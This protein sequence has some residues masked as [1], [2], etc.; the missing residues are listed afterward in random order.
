MVMVMKDVEMCVVYTSRIAYRG[1]DRLD[2][3]VKSGRGLGTLLAPTWELVGGIK[4]HETQGIDPRWVK[5]SP[6]T[7]EQY[8]QGYYELLRARYQPN[9]EGFLAILRLDRVVCCYC[10]AG[11]FC[12][13]YLAVDILEKI[14]IAKGLPFERG[15]ELTIV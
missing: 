1:Q 3:T 14:A 10:Q 15:G 7:Q 8:I 4:H 2:T 13:R 6:I 12:H 5:Y 11:V 9:E